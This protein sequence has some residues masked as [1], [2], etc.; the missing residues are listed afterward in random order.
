LGEVLRLLTTSEVDL[1]V[2]ED[3]AKLLR[4]LSPP[5][6]KTTPLFFCSIPFRGLG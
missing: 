5:E 3:V 2:G 6:K 1:I 4:A